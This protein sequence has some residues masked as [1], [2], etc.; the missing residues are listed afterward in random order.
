MPGFLKMRLWVLTRRSGWVSADPYS[1]CLK[2]QVKVIPDPENPGMGDFGPP[3]EIRETTDSG[4]SLGFRVLRVSRYLR[5]EE[6]PK[7]LILMSERF[8]GLGCK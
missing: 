4:E 5:P 8:R 6:P 1:N 3:D 7:S 2:L